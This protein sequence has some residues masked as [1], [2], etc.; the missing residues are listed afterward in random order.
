MRRA[1]FD[2][3]AIAKLVSEERESLPLVEFLAAPLEAC[4]SALSEIEVPRALLRRGFSLDE[5]RAALGGFYIIGVDA[6]IR[7]RAGSLTPF[8]LRSLDAIHLATALEVAATGLEVVTYDDR[9]ADA[10]RGLGLTVA[11]PGRKRAA[12][13]GRGAAR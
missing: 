11:Q 5:V 8:T 7:A 6:P 2:A 3:S 9:L 1:Y 13:V 12:P 10:A 4:T